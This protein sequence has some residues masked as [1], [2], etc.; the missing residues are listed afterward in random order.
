MSVTVEIKGIQAA[1]ARVRE[2][3]K[4]S[5]EVLAAT[6]EAGAE[7]QS[8]ARDLA[9]V[10]TGTLVKSIQFRM[11]GQ[12][13]TVEAKAGYAGFV[14]FGTTRMRAQPFFTPAF[15]TASGTYE[16]KLRKILAAA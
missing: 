10:D 15:V 16:I 4:V 1:I 8:E 2:V 11:N 6:A 9:P 12:M 13:A 7:M 14:E 5:G 3:A